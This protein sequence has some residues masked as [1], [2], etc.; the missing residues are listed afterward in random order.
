[1]ERDLGI[2]ENTLKQLSEINNLEFS[3]PKEEKEPYKEKYQARKKYEDLLEDHFDNLSDESVFLR[4][5]LKANLARNYFDTEENHQAKTKCKESLAE[6]VALK[7]P[8]LFFNSVT[9]LTYIMNNLGYHA[10]LSERYYEGVFY[11]DISEKIYWAIKS[12]LVLLQKEKESEPKL[13]QANQ[14][15]PKENILKTFLSSG[16]I[17]KATML[18]VGQYLKDE[19]ISQL[20]ANLEKLKQF[21]EDPESNLESPQLVRKVFTL[22]KTPKNLEKDLDILEFDPEIGHPC[23]KDLEEN[24]IQTVF[25]AAQ[26]HAKLMEKDLSAEYCGKTLQR[27]FFK[28]EMLKRESS[29]ELKLIREFDY[30]DF[31]NNSMGLS[32]YYSENLMYKQSLNLL[33]LAQSILIPEEE[34]E[35]Y[36]IKGSLNHM[37]AN[38]IRDFFLH[39]CL[40]FKEEGIQ[41]QESKYKF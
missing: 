14:I 22:T 4:G 29:G 10:V 35:H 13:E 31:C 39:T 3:G 18:S 6:L 25:F 5:V 41:R 37:K 16:A 38:V 9:W 12:N 8:Q 21:T 36:L 26:V 24:Y 17:S 1:M 28:L 2:V 19:I 11:L 33:D 23:M 27:Q 34:E 32:M 30:K 20:S 7:N 15:Q 40:I